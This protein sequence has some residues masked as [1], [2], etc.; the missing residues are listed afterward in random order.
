MVSLPYFR[1]KTISIML[2]IEALDKDLRKKLN[3]P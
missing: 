3:L 1:A 2:P